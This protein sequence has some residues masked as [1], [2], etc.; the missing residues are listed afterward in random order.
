MYVTRING[1]RLLL[2]QVS[3]AHV[4]LL[5]DQLSAETAARIQAQV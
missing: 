4:T 5:K 3:L 1:L 2:L